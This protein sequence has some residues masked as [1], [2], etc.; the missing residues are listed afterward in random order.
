M[1]VPVVVVVPQHHLL[2]Y[3]EL[4]GL[5]LSRDGK[6]PVWDTKKKQKIQMVIREQPSTGKITVAKICLKKSCTPPLT[7]VMRQPGGK[8]SMTAKMA[9]TMP[10]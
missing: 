4:Q 6:Q 7:T 3:C 1:L 5:V 8:W 9:V 10:P 2:E